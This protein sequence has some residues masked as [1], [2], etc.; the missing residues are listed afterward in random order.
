MTDNLHFLSVNCDIVTQYLGV[1]VSFL[2]L[3][4][5]LLRTKCRSYADKMKA[6]YLQFVPIDKY[7]VGSASAQQSQMT[8]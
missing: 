2:T 8:M 5:F 3:L 1:V 4:G 6:L 7:S